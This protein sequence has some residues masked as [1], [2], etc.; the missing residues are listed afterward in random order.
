MATEPKKTYRQTPSKIMELW[1]N[2]YRLLEEY[3]E[4]DR[5]LTELEKKYKG[6]AKNV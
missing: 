2:V 5:Q 1:D 4:F 3:K 6:I